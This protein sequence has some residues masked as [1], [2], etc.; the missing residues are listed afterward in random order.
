MTRKINCPQCGR[1]TEYDPKNPSRPFC[2][3]RCRLIDLGEW[4]NEG[5][6]V[7]GEYD[8]DALGS[9]EHLA[10]NELH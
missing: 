10:G 2:S 6:Q 3:E 7:P 9:D 4:A 8:L 5:Y 1:K